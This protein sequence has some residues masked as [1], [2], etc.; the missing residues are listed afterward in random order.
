MISTSTHRAYKSVLAWLP[1]LFAPVCLLTL[2]CGKKDSNADK[3]A[4]A[5]PC[6]K[7]QVGWQVASASGGLKKAGISTQPPGHAEKLMSYVPNAVH[8]W[9]Q[10]CRTQKKWKCGSTAILWFRVDG[11]GKVTSAKGETD[12]KSVV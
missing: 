12:R 8:G 1:C 2:G 3:T 11:Q 9:I 10:K 6:R 7:A 5:G 4:G